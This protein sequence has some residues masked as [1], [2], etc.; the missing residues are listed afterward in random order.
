MDSR[1]ELNST[2]RWWVPLSY[3]SKAHPD[4]VQCGWIPEYSDQV[5]TSLEATE[6]QWVIFNIDQ[7]GKQYITVFILLAPI[8][9]F[10]FF[11]DIIVLIMTNTIGV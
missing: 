8:M 3:S 1:Q 11:Q 2:Y 5:N 10:Y 7:V 9:T 4:V 6:N